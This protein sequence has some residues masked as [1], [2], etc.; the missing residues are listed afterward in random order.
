MAD[1]IPRSR[2]RLR[3]LFNRQGNDIIGFFSEFVPLVDSTISLRVLLAYV[4]FELERGQ[5]LTLY[6]GARKIQRTDA[7]LT[8]K[9]LNNQHI[10]RETFLKFFNT[11]Y[12]FDLP[13]TVIEIIK[14]AEKTR[15]KLMHGKDVAEAEVRGAIAR[16]I[17]YSK[18]INDLMDSK[19]IHFHPFSADLRGFAGR[20]ESLEKATSRWILK[21][22][23]FE[24]R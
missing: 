16:V 10:T 7:D 2:P 14:P 5:S 12:S 24:I 3:D 15:D 6:L 21:G 19:N 17:Q 18:A 20:C 22:M 8:W 11:I 4:F 13:Q 23:G 9:A 1:S